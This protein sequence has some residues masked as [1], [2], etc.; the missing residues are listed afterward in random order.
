MSVELIL[1]SILALSMITVGQ[2]QSPPGCPYLPGFE[3]LQKQLPGMKGNAAVKALIRYRAEHENPV[4]CEA[5]ELERLISEREAAMLH[6]VARTAQFQAQAV[7][8]CAAYDPKTTKCDGDVADGTAHPFSAGI[9]PFP[10]PEITP[11]T[12]VSGLR[13]SK[14][15]AVYTA[16]LPDLLDGKP[17]TPLSRR[18][19]TIEI[20]LKTKPY[21]LI[22]I[23][24]GSGPRTY[25]K[26][27]WYFS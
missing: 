15:M 25:L 2:S 22:A 12:I 16:A 23:F 10:A 20:D 9:Q 19:R 4:A 17:A 13:H 21:V 6:L 24:K 5:I 18:G 3:T 7:Y 1:Q 27:T 8:H 14:L 26:A 11:L